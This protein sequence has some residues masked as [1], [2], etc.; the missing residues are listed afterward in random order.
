MNHTL[1]AMLNYKDTF[2]ALN[3]ILQWRHQL[4]DSLNIG[5]CQLADG[6]L[7][8]QIVSPAR[9]NAVIKNVNRQ[10]P[11]GWSISSDEHWVAYRESTVTVAS[12]EHHFRNFIQVL[13]FDH[14]QQY[15]LFQILNLPG[16][17][18]NGTHS[19]SFSNLP[20]FPAVAADLETFLELSKDDAWECKKIFRTLCKFHTGI[21]KRNA[22]KSYAIA[23]FMNY[24]PRIKKQ[25]RSNQWAFSATVPRDIVFSC[26]P[27]VGQPPLRTDPTSNSSGKHVII[28]IPRKNTSS[29]DIISELLQR[30][31]RASARLAAHEQHDVVSLPPEDRGRD[32]LEMQ[33]LQSSG[34]F[35]DW[36]VHLEATLD[37]A[38][39]EEARKLRLMRLKLYGETVEEF[40]NFKLDNPIR[41]KEYSA[42]KERLLKLFHSTKTSSQRSV[43]FH[44]MKREPEENMRRY[45]NRIR[46]PI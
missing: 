27:N 24:V 20:N 30:N 42:V 33:N 28:E 26:P 35:D 23:A 44:N 25:W 4:A 34:R 16:A 29:I 39:F 12:L 40:D 43:E 11:R 32:E 37:L 15:K 2:E 38:N 7:A 21:S 10:L 3:Q 6:N 14:A 13:I 1:A 8:P 9:F 5:F 36:A 31:D 22:R 45:A 46:K 41:V 18:D 19:V 17:A